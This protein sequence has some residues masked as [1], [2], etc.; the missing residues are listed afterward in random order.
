MD[1]TLKGTNDLDLAWLMAALFAG[2]A[3]W[4]LTQG[5]GYAVVK[6]ACAGGNPFLLGAIALVGL[7]IAS[8]GAWLGWRRSA[9]LRA[10]ATDNGGHDIDRSYFIAVVATGLDVLIALLIVT[11]ALSQLWGRCE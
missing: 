4:V 10:V 2:P 7:V 5:A 9:S 6:P 8:A 11:T 1:T 3:G